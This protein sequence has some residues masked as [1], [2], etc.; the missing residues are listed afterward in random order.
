MNAL[1]TELAIIIQQNELDIKGFSDKNIWRMKQFYETY[2]DPVHSLHKQ[3]DKCFMKHFCT[4]KFID[5]T[6][7]P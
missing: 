2:K 6:L 1:V 3:N 7:L 4:Y 5:K